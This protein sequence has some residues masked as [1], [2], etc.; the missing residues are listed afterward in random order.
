MKNVISIADTFCPKLGQIYFK[1]SSN[2]VTFTFM[3]SRYSE[4]P[5]GGPRMYV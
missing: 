4:E 5:C 3:N 2:E 1:L